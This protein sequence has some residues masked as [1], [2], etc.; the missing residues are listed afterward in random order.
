MAAATVN[1]WP[2]ELRGRE[3]ILRKITSSARERPSYH[4]RGQRADRPAR[5]LKLTHYQPFRAALAPVSHLR[6]LDGDA[7]LGRDAFANARPSGR[8]DLEVLR[9]HRRNRLDEAAERLRFVGVQV[10]LDPLVQRRNLP[11]HDLDC[12]RFLLRVAPIDVESSLHA[13]RE[14]QRYAC[15]AADVRGVTVED[16]RHELNDAACGMAEK[17]DRVFDPPGPY[18]RAAVDRHPNGLRQRLSLGFTH[19]AAADQRDRPLE[20]RTVHLVGDHALTERLQRSLRK[21]RLGRAVA[22][23]HH[24][25]ARSIIASST[26]SAS[27][28]PT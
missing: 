20:K 25:P 26:A 16:L 6:V 13:R 17:V 12:G 10:A 4:R 24:L 15:L 3:G 14:Q 9:A 7:A 1:A 18:E 11:L 28:A 22:I 8:R 2:K 5:Q 19:D 23:E 27:D 21:G